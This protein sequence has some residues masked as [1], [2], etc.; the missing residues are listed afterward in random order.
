M[1]PTPKKLFKTF[2]LAVVF[3]L[4]IVNLNVLFG[5]SG[6]ED[7]FFSNDPDF[8]VGAPAIGHPFRPINMSK[9][10]WYRTGEVNK[11]NSST[12]LKA[13]LPKQTRLL[14][15]TALSANATLKDI[16][17]FLNHQQKIM[18]SEVFGEKLDKDSIVVVVQVHNRVD[19]LNYLIQ[20][21][22]RVEGKEQL[23][24]IF[25]HD[26]YSAEINS[27]I[28]QITFCKVGNSYYWFQAISFNGNIHYSL[29]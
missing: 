16:V 3:G 2:C 9:H 24:L 20:S 7:D 5:N 29:L 18:N 27:L 12:F 17:Q 13:H 26:F 25:S 10:N 11:F 8:G 19:Y 21:L 22:S 6:G 23:L 1:R 15:V 28:D 4:F 14:N